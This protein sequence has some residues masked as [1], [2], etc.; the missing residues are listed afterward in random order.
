MML[1]V[2]AHNMRKQIKFLKINWKGY[3]KIRIAQKQMIKK[4][5]ERLLINVR[6]FSKIPIKWLSVRKLALKC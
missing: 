6:N 4:Y 2:V 3:I 1:I 5:K